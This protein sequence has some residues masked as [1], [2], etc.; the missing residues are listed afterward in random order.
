MDNNGAQKRRVAEKRGR[1]AELI[2]ELFLLTKGFRTVARR[3]KTKAGEVDLIARRG[4][5]VLMVEVKARPTLSEALDAVTP[6]AQRRIEAAGDIWLS[7]QSDYGRLSVRYDLIAIL[8]RRW[9][10]HVASIYTL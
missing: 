3:F 1:R 7:R 5:L 10:V 6:F 4:D 8:P 2:A 9:P